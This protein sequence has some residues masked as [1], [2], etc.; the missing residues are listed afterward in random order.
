M[1][2]KH[3][4]IQNDKP[5]QFTLKILESLYNYPHD[6]DKVGLYECEFC[7]NKFLGISLQV[8]DSYL[9]YWVNAS[10]DEI[11]NALAMKNEFE[12]FDYTKKIIEVKKSHIFCSFDGNYY[13]KNETAH[14]LSGR[15]KW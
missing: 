13:I 1:K 3:C 9:S 4:E 11:T 2:C 5:I 15:P 8:Y 10:K 7:K 12:V 6:T 14:V